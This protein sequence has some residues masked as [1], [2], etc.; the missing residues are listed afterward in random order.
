MKYLRLT[1]TDPYRNLAIEEYLFTHTKEDW[2][3]LW[4]NES[5]VVI[6]NNQNAYAEVDLSYAEA[7][8][9]RV[10]RRI[11]GGGAVF[12]DGGNINFSFITGN[13]HALDYAYFAA[14]ITEALRALGLPAALGGR[15]DILVGDRK[16][17]GNAQ[18]TKNG[19]TLHH[20]TLLYDTDPA[21]MAGVLRI[22][23]EKLA[24]HA[25]RSHKS[26]VVNI[27]AL[28]DLSLTPLAF[29]DAFEERLLA[30]TGA[31]PTPLPDD[32][33]IEALAARNASPAWILADRRFLISYTL[34]RRIK[35]PAGIVELS[36]LLSRNRIEKATV[37]GDFFECAPI[38]ELEAALRGLTTA[39]AAVLDPTP[40]LAG[41]TAAEWQRLFEEEGSL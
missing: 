36:L 11:T 20:G 27:R 34:T 25:V 26:R 5:T 16:I 21:Q 40:Y 3:L 29:L 35:F 32:P 17:S 13:A 23:R 22:D 28:L 37:S 31:T 7:H 15:N 10:A 18:T 39:E 38:A 8:G 14:P 41:I 33:M 24:Y 9:I 19:R 30:I 6:G 12:H 2:L 4:Q 1:S